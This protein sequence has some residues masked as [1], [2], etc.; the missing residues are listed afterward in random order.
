MSSTSIVYIQGDHRS[1]TELK[2][3]AYIQASPSSRSTL[4]HLAAEAPLRLIQ[5][6]GV[7]LFYPSVLLYVL[8][9]G[10]ACV[11]HNNTTS[12]QKSANII[13]GQ[14]LQDGSHPDMITKEPRTPR[15]HDEQPNLW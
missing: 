8:S 13:A 12:I 6:R 7:L 15:A 10:V 5:P 2:S 9:K 14:E 1:G 4:R 11:V 3:F